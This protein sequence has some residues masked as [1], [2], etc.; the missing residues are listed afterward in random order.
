[1]KLWNISVAPDAVDDLD[2]ARLLEELARGVGQRLAR[3]DA[4]LQRAQ[5][6]VLPDSR[7]R[8]VHGRRREEDGRL[9]LL[10]RLEHRVRREPSRPAP[11]LAPKRSGKHKRPPSP[12]VKASGGEPMKMSSCEA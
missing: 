5:V 6:V 8:A 7:K 1:M 10:D 12:K 11:V 4:F 2:A 3:R 9:E